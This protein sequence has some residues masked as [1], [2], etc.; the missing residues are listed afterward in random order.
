M[1]MC[2]QIDNGGTPRLRNTF[3]SFVNHCLF[4]P[5]IQSDVRTGVS[6]YHSKD[7]SGLINDKRVLVD[8][9]RIL[10]CAI[11]KIKKCIYIEDGSV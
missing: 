2:G 10:P 6:V 11:E 4:A 8:C 5:S 9:A 3:L 1:R 7:S